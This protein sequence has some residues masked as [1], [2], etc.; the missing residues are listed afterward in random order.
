MREGGREGVRKEKPSKHTYLRY[1]LGVG[2]DDR[3]PLLEV[4]LGFG[5]SLLHV[6]AGADVK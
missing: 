6:V 2:V 3:D 4:L 5:Q 1:A